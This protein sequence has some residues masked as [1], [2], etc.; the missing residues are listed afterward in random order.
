[1]GKDRCEISPSAFVQRDVRCLTM[2]R[3]AQIV[4]VLSLRRSL[5]PLELDLST[6]KMRAQPWEGGLDYTLFYLSEIFGRRRAP[7]LNEI[8]D[9]RIGCI[10]IQTG[11]PAWRV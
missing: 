10:L 9:K 1:M 7:S 4:E 8:A 3:A 11:A 5:S 2:C 6:L